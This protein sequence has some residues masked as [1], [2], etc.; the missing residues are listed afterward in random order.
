M[1]AKTEAYSKLLTSMLVS[2][3]GLRQRD[4]LTDLSKAFSD[5]VSKVEADGNW[6]VQPNKDAT[7]PLGLAYYKFLKVASKYPYKL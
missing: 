3:C 7:S 1:A 4:P 6:A 2:R 5:F